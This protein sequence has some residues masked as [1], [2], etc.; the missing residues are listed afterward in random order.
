MWQ[1]NR[2]L[3]VINDDS[4]SER[5]AYAFERARNMPKIVLKE[6]AAAAKEIKIGKEK[7]IFD[8]WIF[9]TGL[10]IDY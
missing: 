3:L 4:D 2:K 9:N 6:R 8:G 10:P 1:K 7:Q 5:C